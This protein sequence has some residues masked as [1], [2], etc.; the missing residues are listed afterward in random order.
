MTTARKIV[1]TSLS[2]ISLEG[3]KN[4]SA[5]CFSNKLLESLCIEQFLRINQFQK[6]DC[7]DVSIFGEPAFIFRIH[8]LR[9]NLFLHSHS[10]TIPNKSAELR[11][12]RQTEL[13]TWGMVPK[14][15]PDSQEPKARR[16]PLDQAGT[17]QLTGT[18][19]NPGNLE[20]YQG[21]RNLNKLEL[22]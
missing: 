3:L 15:S 9:M 14:A 6:A 10:N 4:A 18:S 16:S 20:E 13:E 7:S 8:T 12:K 21:K 2:C 17:R 22:K 11:S 5:C 19:K 1:W